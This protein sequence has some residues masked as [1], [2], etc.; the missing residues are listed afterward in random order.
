MLETATLLG[1]L[2]LAILGADKL[3]DGALALRLFRRPQDRQI[4]GNEFSGRIRRVCRVP[5]TLRVTG[6]L[7]NN[8]QTVRFSA[9]REAAWRERQALAR[10]GE[11]KNFECAF[12]ACRGARLHGGLAAL[13]KRR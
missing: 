8:M 11:K 9:E 10:R 3:V 2:L 13:S 1:G 12:S 6:C 5:D 7:L 4:Q